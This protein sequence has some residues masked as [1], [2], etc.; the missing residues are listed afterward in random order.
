MSK[1]LDFKHKKVIVF[2][3]DGTIVD[4]DVNWT[5]LKNLLSKKFSTIYSE[6]CEFSS[7]SRCLSEIVKRNDDDTLIDFIDIV[8][9]HELK[10]LENSEILRETVFFINNP[11]LFGVLDGTKLAVFSLNTRKAIKEALKLANITDQIDYIIGREDVR[12]WKP[13]PSGLLKIQKHYNVKKEEMIYF[14]DLKKD[15]ITGE[16]AGIDA[17]LIDEII[18]LVKKRRR[19]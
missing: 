9:E 15:L 6:S 8:R 1:L 3:L 13:N 12:K 2:D 10:D 11:G 19:K 7:I 16:N 14:G 4:L 5:H 18:K 17:F